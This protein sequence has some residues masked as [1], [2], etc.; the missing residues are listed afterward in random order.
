MVI[1]M[2]KLEKDNMIFSFNRDNKS[3]FTVDDGEI[4]QIE[5]DDCYCGQINS[6]SILRTDIDISIMDA[7]VGPV[8]IN[9]SSPNDIL[10][11][12]IIDIEFEDHGVMVTSPGLGVLGDKINNADTK[13]I[14]IKDNVAIFSDNIKIPLTP[15][16]GV[17]GVA[18]KKGDIH[19]S[20]PGDHG[21][22]MDTKEVK[23]GSKIFLPVNIEGANLALAD[24]H[25]CMGDGELSGTG[26]ETAGTV[27]LKVDVIKNKELL[28]PVIET[29]SH[30]FTLHTAETFEEAMYVAV[31]DMVTLIMDKLRLDFQ[32]AYRLL[33]ATCDIRVSQVVNG[34]ITMKVALPRYVIEWKGYIS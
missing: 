21:G 13:I 33:S 10:C 26:I 24:L 22:N 19:C 23:K 16:V 8:K 27:T 15:M 18:P 5:T 25:A 6:E 32:D 34:V 7:A 31:D 1:Y 14:P 28:H 9:N 2:R 29:K 30:I 3:V 20:I 17:L 12:E 4:F 11:I